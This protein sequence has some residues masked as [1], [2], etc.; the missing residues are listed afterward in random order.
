MTTK[1]DEIQ[2]DG[3]HYKDMP[4]QPWDVMA[5]ELTKEEFIGYLK[6]NI[7]KYTMRAGRKGDASIDL[8]K[9]A[10]YDQKLQEVLNDR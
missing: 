10:H 9:A 8:A 2:V 6:G 1:A 3:S 5:E 7:I 4:R